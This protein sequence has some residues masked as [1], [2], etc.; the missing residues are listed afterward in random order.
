MMKLVMAATL[1]LGAAG[2]TAATIDVGPQTGSFTGNTRGYFFTA[3]VDFT[4]TGLFVATDASTANQDI[5]V[6]RLGAVPPN[7][8][9]VTNDFT[10]LALIRDD[11]SATFVPTSIQFFAG[12]IVGILGSR[13]VT[14]TNS[15]GSGNYVTDLGG[16]AI[17]LQRLGMQ[18]Q[19][20]S[21]DPQSVWTEAGGAISRVFFT[22]EVGTPGVIPE[23]AT[24]GMLIAGF[25]LVGVAARRRR[26]AP[27]NA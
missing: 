19:L 1:L 24:W 20:R 5:A 15:Y 7:F 9:S 14:A 16:N 23:P 12:D 4:I 13:G 3:P 22:Y 21:T 17:T 2:A 8:S 27:A 25:G 11:G 10:T 18:F 6:L 26:L